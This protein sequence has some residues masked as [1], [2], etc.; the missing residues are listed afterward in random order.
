[1]PGTAFKLVKFMG[2]GPKVSP[3]LLPETVAQIAFN[4]DIS[5]GDLLPYRRSETLLTL[6]KP[7]TIKEIYPMNDGAGGYK[8]L[9]WTTD[10]DV[11]TSQ[12][13]GDTTQRI[14]YSGDGVPKVT[15]YPLATSGAQYPT[16]SYTLGLPL[17]TAVPSA[18]AVAF[19]QKTSTH[20]GRDSGGTAYVRSVAHGLRTGN[21]ITTTG[22]SGTGYNLTNAP[23]TVLDADSFSYF[24]F[25]AAEGSYPD[26]D[27]G[28]PATAVADTGGKI[29]L[30]GVVA[31]RTY[32]YTYFT[33]WDEESVPSEP[34]AAVFVKEGQ[35]VTLTGLPTSWTHGAGYQETGMKL[36]IYRTV[37]GTTGSEYFRVG[38]MPL[39]AP[40]SGTYSRTGTLI[41]VTMTAHNLTTDDH[42]TLD[43]TT[44]TATDGGYT[45]TVVDANTF[46][47]V[48]LTSGATSG[49]VTRTAGVFTDNID[50]ETLDADLILESLDY[51]QPEPTMQGMLTVHNGMI[52]GFFGNTVCFCEPNKPHAWPIKYRKQ[53]DSDI[54]G[55]GAF[56]ST[57][58]VLT[59]KTP[60]K[61]G[62]NNP[63]AMYLERTDFIL[64]CLSKRSIVNI[65]FGVMWSS[66]GGLAVFSSSI[67]GTDYIT[68]NVHSWTTWPAAVT[69]AA[70]VGQYY[71][72]RY[73]GSDG[74]N[75]FIFER[76]DQMGGHLVSSDV[77]FSCAYYVAAT[78]AFYYVDGSDLHLWNSPNMGPSTLDWKSKVFTTKDYMNLGACRVIADYSTP[79]GEAALAAANDAIVAS[80]TALMGA[81]TEGGPL[82]WDAVGELGV[83]ESALTPL[84]LPDYT[85][86][87][88]LYVD[89][90]LV[91][92]KVVTGD[93]PFRLP[94]GYRS[95]TFEFRVATTARVRAIHVAETPAGLRGA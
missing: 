16:Q 63:E 61:L 47:V 19:S 4:L 87:F 40:T 79:E 24:T 75:T 64:P 50:V 46:T 58:L 67:V 36:R 70:L 26:P 51:D 37:A 7:G 56:G 2:A 21:Y 81:G 12:I 30:A 9:H 91:F 74:T 78:D 6:D 1:M 39:V 52:V 31:P 69:P 85:A 84:Q 43:F 17:P 38:E 29:D 62:G 27:S 55:L 13:E 33:A 34:T 18:A 3:E 22:F 82:D 60:W 59:D 41:T 5:S 23:V 8:W 28:V 66:A 89:K 48:D 68:K 83:A 71:R 45:V 32:V 54:V 42:V 72:G 44:G 86:T 80:N 20:R 35:V 95:D 53:I 92:T 73:F 76:N 49:N 14:Y 10:V 65:G 15:N 11:A 94:T 90:K 57:I 77:K 25:G 88:Q 93:A